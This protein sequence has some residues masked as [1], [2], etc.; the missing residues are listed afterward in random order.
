MHVTATDFLQ[1]LGLPPAIR[2]RNPEGRTIV[3]PYKDEDE[4]WFYI[5]ADLVRRGIDPEPYMPLAP[6][7]AAPPRPKK[8]LDDFLWY[9]RYFGDPLPK[10]VVDYLRANGKDVGS[11][12]PYCPS[13]DEPYIHR[14]T[15]PTEFYRLVSRKGQW[16]AVPYLVTRPQKKGRPAKGDI[17]EFVAFCLKTPHPEYDDEKALIEQWAFDMM[18]YH[19]TR[20]S[21]SKDNPHGICC[22]GSDDD[23]WLPLCYGVFEGPDRWKWWHAYNG[24]PEFFDQAPW[25]RVMPCTNELVRR[26]NQRK[27]LEEERQNRIQELRRVFSRRRLQNLKIEAEGIKLQV[28]PEKDLGRF[29]IPIEVRDDS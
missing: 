18:R 10:A 20:F 14:S 15:G 6:F 11:V 17:G 7:V 21:P 12:L 27:T 28:V 23:F 25:N 2:A 5:R 29:T 3:T 16:F 22:M 4:K 1:I 9:S 8:T 13:V 19:Q 26:W 24:G